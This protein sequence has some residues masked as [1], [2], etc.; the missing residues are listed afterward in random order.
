[1]NLKHFK[2]YV[3]SVFTTSSAAALMFAD[4]VSLFKYCPFQFMSV[5]QD[6]RTIETKSVT[7]IQLMSSNALAAGIKITSDVFFIVFFQRTVV[8]LSRHY[9]K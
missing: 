4:D 6:N 9:Q 7:A 2:V 5:F 1:M 8:A 3:S